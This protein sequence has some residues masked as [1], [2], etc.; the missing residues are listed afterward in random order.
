MTEDDDATQQRMLIWLM[1]I[2]GG[3]GCGGFVIC[4]PVGG[5]LS[6]LWR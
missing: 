6:M 3:I 5:M 2:A 4:T 1:V